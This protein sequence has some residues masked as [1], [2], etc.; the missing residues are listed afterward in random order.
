MEES[1]KEGQLGDKPKEE[2]VQ[3]QVATIITLYNDKMEALA[4]IEL[5]PGAEK[6]AARLKLT[7]RLKKQEMEAIQSIL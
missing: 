3:G 6:N 4:Q 7:R 1:F 5:L 2:E